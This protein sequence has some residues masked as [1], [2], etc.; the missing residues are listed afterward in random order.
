[1][2]ATKCRHALLAGHFG[3]DEP[4]VPCNEMCDVCNHAVSIF[5]RFFSPVVSGGIPICGVRAAGRN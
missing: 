1:M 4:P 2:N 5:A 3:E